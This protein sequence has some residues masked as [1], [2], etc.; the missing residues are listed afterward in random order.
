VFEDQRRRALGVGR[1]EQHRHD[2]A[3]EGS[4]DRR[5]F[6]PCVVEDGANVVHPF[7]ERGQRL[8]RDGIG[9]AH[10]SLVED[11]D[12]A[13]RPEPA[14][15][16]R[17]ERKLP[18]ALDVAL[19]GTADNE[20]EGPLAEYLIGDV[21]ISATREPR[22]GNVHRWQGAQAWSNRQASAAGG[23]RARNEYVCGIFRRRSAA[24]LGNASQ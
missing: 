9:Q 6:G 16:L 7:L 5:S 2:A 18:P 13:K 22:L 21:H 24:I 8:E 10:P 17:H 15:E 4:V 14:E 19:P 11:N 3:V 12:P 1:G 20:I 23:F